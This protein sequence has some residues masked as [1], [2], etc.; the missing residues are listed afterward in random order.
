MAA[1]AP[2]AEQ[3]DLMFD[4]TRR[5]TRQGYSHVENVPPV[6][7][8]IALGATD[9]NVTKKL[10]FDFLKTGAAAALA[11]ALTRIE[12]EGA[13]AEPAL[14]RRLGLSEKFPDII[15]GADINRWIRTWCFAQD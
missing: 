3:C 2:F 13:S 5:D 12:T 8:A 4:R 10:H 14:T 7:P 9:E 1:L 15:E 6:P 11:L